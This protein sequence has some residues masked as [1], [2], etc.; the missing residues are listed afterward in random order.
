MLLGSNMAHNAV[1]SFEPNSF[2]VLTTCSLWGHPKHQGCFQSRNIDESK[3]ST[4]LYLCY[5]TSSCRRLPMQRPVQ[6]KH[7]LLL[8]VWKSSQLLH[9]DYI[10]NEVG[11]PYRKLCRIVFA[12]N[13]RCYRT[14]YYSSDDHWKG[15][16]CGESR[17]WKSK[18]NRS[19]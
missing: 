6:R 5:G 13:W 1:G 19:L 9:L 17:N 14:P 10:D 3:R 2:V 18:R 16:I 12:I 4:I 7:C 8:W 11:V 15:H